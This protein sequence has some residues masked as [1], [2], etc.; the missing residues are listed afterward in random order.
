MLYYIINY[1]S[2]LI[3]ICTTTTTNTKVPYTNIRTIITST[4]YI[5][6]NTTTFTTTTIL[7]AP[8]LLFETNDLVLRSSERNVVL[9]LLE[10]ARRGASYGII[11]PLIIQ[12]IITH[13]ISDLYNCV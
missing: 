3:T 6:T 2:T 8:C 11:T 10:V 7:T 1:N 13:Y 4:T 9:C 12:V 5:T